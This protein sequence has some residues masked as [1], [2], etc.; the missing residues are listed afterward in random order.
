MRRIPIVG[1]TTQ[2]DRRVK[3]AK[4]KPE[5]RLKADCSKCSNKSSQVVAYSAEID[6]MEAFDFSARQAKD[7]EKMQLKQFRI[8]NK[9]TSSMMNRISI[10]LFN[11]T[12]FS[13]IFPVSCLSKS[14]DRWLK[15]S[16][17]KRKGHNC[18]YYH[19]NIRI[20]NF[21]VLLRSVGQICGNVERSKYSVVVVMNLRAW[22]NLQ[23]S[24]HSQ[25][26]CPERSPL[27]KPT[28][29]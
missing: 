3:E 4:D 9:W 5:F 22:E 8:R 15:N 25:Q 28:I 21:V 13:L 26:R 16:H 6:V 14:Y 27:S 24:E 10:C 12:I 2:M 20:S 29:L 18:N 7:D 23:H 11:N 19:E 1:K 17:K